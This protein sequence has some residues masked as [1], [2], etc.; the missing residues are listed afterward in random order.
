MY[1][2][3]LASTEHRSLGTESSQLSAVHRWTGN[4]A[5]GVSLGFTVQS[6]EKAQGGCSCDKDEGLCCEVMS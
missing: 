5:W 3:L 2:S 6:F 1:V 4:Q